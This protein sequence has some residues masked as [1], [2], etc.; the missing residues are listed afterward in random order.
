[1]VKK[2]L[3]YYHFNYWGEP[4]DLLIVPRMKIDSIMHLAHS[5]LL[6]GY[7]RPQNIL[8]KIQAQFHWPGMVVKLCNFC[9]HCPQ[10][11]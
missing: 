1:M 5:H 9:Q 3:L 4:C 6:G 11:Q 7:L 8:E 10:C 2:G